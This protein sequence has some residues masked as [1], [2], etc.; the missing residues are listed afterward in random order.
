LGAVNRVEAQLTAIDRER[1][2][3][4]ATVDAE[5]GTATVRMRFIRQQNGLWTVSELS[6]PAVARGS[7]K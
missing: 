4:T 7:R 5:G 2:G 6:D 3:A 1:A